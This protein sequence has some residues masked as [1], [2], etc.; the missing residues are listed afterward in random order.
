MIVS[1]CFT[2][3]PWEAQWR[4]RDLSLLLPPGVPNRDPD[5]RQRPLCGPRHSGQRPERPPVP[6]PGQLARLH[7]QLRPVLCRQLRHVR[8]RVLQVSE[9]NGTRS[10]GCLWSCLGYDSSAGC[11]TFRA[12]RSQCGRMQLRSWTW[13]KVEKLLLCHSSVKW[14]RKRIRE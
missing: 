5:P 6:L 13:F 2:S 8:V 14:G 1:F 12:G 7:R 3:D 4:L 9:F 10:W 11:A